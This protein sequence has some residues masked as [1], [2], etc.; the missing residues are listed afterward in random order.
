MSGT[1]IFFSLT[2]TESLR[3]KLL[4]LDPPKFRFGELIHII[5]LAQKISLFHAR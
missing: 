3:I 1:E 4:G 5:S 2:Q